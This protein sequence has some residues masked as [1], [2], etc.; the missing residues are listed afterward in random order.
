[1][2]SNNKTASIH[3]PRTLRGRS[4]HEKGI[5]PD[6]VVEIP[7]DMWMGGHDLEFDDDPQLQRAIELFQ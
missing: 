7:E 4:I 5:E 1:M 2:K 6:Y 3:L